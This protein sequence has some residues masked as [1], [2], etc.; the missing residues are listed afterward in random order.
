MKSIYKILAFAFALLSALVVG[1]LAGSIYLGFGL[2]AMAVV[3]SFVPQDGEVAYALICGLVGANQGPD[4]DFP[5]VGGA[6]DRL[7][8]YN[9]SEIA[10]YTL[11][12]TNKEIVEAITMVALKKGFSYDGQNYSTQPRWRYVEGP[13]AGAF[14]HE[15]EFLVFNYTG[16]IKKE[17]LALSK[18]KLVAVT[19]SNFRGDDGDAAY[20]IFG[21]QA[22]MKVVEME[23]DF[24]SDI[25]GAIRVKIKSNPKGLE[26]S[27]PKSVFI[28]DYATTN[29]MV[30]GT[31]TP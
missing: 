24:N 1:Y 31:I 29:T 18:A 28:T 2:F 25:Q 13:F 15:V 14:E 8:L 10:G 19:L 9:F 26:G 16:A 27:I 6:D 11:N 3:F 5:L 12:A 20:H 21:S 4:C 30:V 7:Y 23:Q 22:G 17:L